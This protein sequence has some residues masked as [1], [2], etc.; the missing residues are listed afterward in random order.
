MATPVGRMGPS[1]YSLPDLRRCPNRFLFYT[2]PL[3]P[4]VTKAARSGSVPTMMVAA[5]NVTIFAQRGA[6]GKVVKVGSNMEKCE[7]KVHE[8]D[9]ATRDGKTFNRF[10]G[11]DSLVY[12]DC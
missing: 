3:D 10:N 11:S 2:G 9:A 8:Y 6:A 1:L 4:V 5:E 7:R 12:R